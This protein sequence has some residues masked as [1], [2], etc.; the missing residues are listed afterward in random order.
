M[1]TRRS[2]SRCTLLLTFCAAAG[3][4]QA[5]TATVARDLAAPCMT[6]HGTGGNAVGNIPPSLA[7]RPAAELLQAMR[8]F[9][10]GK[11]PATIMHR[12]AKGYTDEQLRLV[13]EYFAAQRPEPPRLPAKP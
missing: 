2:V 11:R 6:C 9:R 1:K 12:Q 3:L 13:S 10:D 7:G 8:D 5:Q 4:A